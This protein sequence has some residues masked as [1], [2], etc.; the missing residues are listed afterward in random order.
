MGVRGYYGANVVSSGNTSGGR[1]GG[2]SGSTRGGPHG[3]GGGQDRSNEIKEKI[4]RQQQQKETQKN[5]AIQ[6]NYNRIK[7]GP[8]RE[9]WRDDPEKVDEWDPSQ[10]IIDRQEKARLD[11][12]GKMEE[13]KQAMLASQE[14]QKKLE[15]QGIQAMSD[16]EIDT[17]RNLFAAQGAG[18]DVTG[19]EA[20]VNKQKQSIVQKWQSGLYDKEQLKNTDEFKSL[21]KL[22]GGDPNNITD[23]DFMAVWYNTFGGGQDFKGSQTAA[24]YD[25]GFDPSGMRTWTDIQDDPS[26]KAAYYG[27]LSDETPTNM[28][29]E[30]LP[31]IGYKNYGPKGG[32]GGGGGWGG[33][34][35]WGGYGG[36]GGGGYAYGPQPGYKPEQM[37]GF[38]TPQAN[39]QQAMV[40]VHGTPTVFKKRGGIVSLLELN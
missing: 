35:D 2:S 17:M 9:D 32:S 7:S 14:L 30:Y 38:Y 28:I 34:G 11:A 25:A 19:A 4:Q 31:Q 27:L 33:W 1:S 37:A 15:K 40:N 12:L 18:M 6:E 16:E 21:I 3:G 36:G 24:G 39:L 23:K 5:K 8:V 20:E 29:R 22:Q 10:D 13:R 26:A